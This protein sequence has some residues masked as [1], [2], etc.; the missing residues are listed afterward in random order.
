MQLINKEKETKNANYLITHS[1]YFSPSK[2]M[3]EISQRII[4]C[5]AVVVS[6]QHLKRV[7]NIVT[8]VTEYFV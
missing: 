3:R 5:R 1:R 8:G 4:L 7:F 2:A 6:C